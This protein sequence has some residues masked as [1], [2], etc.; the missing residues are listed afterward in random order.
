MN[1]T[2][3]KAK[4]AS[5]NLRNVL[6]QPLTIDWPRIPESEIKRCSRF[7]QEVERK[8]IVSGCNGVIRLLQSGQVLACFILDSFNPKVFG[9]LI[10]QMA[11]KRNPSVLVLAVPSFPVDCGRNSTFMAV[12]KLKENEQSDAVQAL[13]SW[14]KDVS[15]R[16]GFI[17]QKQADGSTI[18]RKK[19]KPP[20]AKNSAVN[21]PM[22]DEEV[23]KFYVYGPAVE[24]KQAM[25]RFAQDTED[26]I[27][28]SDTKSDVSVSRDKYQQPV[29][30][31]TK[32]F[33]PVK[34]TYVPL[35][36]NRVQG[37]PN[38]VEHKKTKQKKKKS[39][40]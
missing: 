32:K 29:Q 39:K 16:N 21:V 8:H 6:A 36:V 13:L 31:R 22:T 20:P 15:L 11:R 7:L 26:F 5:K 17:T 40:K 9:K 38:R 1:K 35:K 3:E 37:N 25:K 19:T 12:T 2:K 4:K 23:A 24:N 27:S 33:K 30:P 14:M 10:I 28:F 18:R 34:S